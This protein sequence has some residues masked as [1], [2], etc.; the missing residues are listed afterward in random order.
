MAIS[1]QLC[2]SPILSEKSSKIMKIPAFQ[3]KSTKHRFKTKRSQP[4]LENDISKKSFDFLSIIP[5]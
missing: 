1:G 3:S 2:L 5:I 4:F